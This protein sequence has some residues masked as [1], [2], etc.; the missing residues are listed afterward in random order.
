MTHKRQ[1]PRLASGP[2]QNFSVRL[3]GAEEAIK[4]IPHIDLLLLLPNPIRL[5]STINN[6]EFVTKC[7]KDSLTI[8]SSGL[9]EKSINFRSLSDPRTE[10][11]KI[12]MI[13]QS[14]IQRQR[15][16]ITKSQ[17][18]GDSV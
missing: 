7:N 17:R 5:N 2:R 11:S 9:A 10:R 18:G 1:R 3:A 13:L 16:P 8:K 14:R 4:P 15:A 12:V 6:K